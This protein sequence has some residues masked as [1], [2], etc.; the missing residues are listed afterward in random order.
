MASAFIVKL[1]LKV[2]PFAPVVRT[3]VVPVEGEGKE[4]T[5]KTAETMER[6]PLTWRRNQARCGN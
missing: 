2:P 4:V 1:E 6:T 3:V 5:N